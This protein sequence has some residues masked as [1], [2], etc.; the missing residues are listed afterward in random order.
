MKAGS[1]ASNQ[2]KIKLIEIIAKKELN[3]GEIAKKARIPLRMTLSLMDEL[4]N[5]G[6]VLRNG[7]F[8]KISKKGEKAIKEIRGDVRGN[9]R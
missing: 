8:Y 9:R 4:L 5:E 6:L 3:A 7:D 2:N 1:L